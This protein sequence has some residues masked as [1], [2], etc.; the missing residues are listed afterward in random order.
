MHDPLQALCEIVAK[1]Y[2]VWRV[3]IPGFYDL[4]SIEQ[5]ERRYLAGTGPSDREILREAGAPAHGAKGSLIYERELRPRL[6]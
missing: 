3:A 4:C 2:A 6:R 5:T 1:L